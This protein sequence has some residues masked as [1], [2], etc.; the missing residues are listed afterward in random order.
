MARCDTLKHT[1]FWSHL[2]RERSARIFRSKQGKQGVPEKAKQ[3]KQGAFKTYPLA[4]A[5]QAKQGLTGRAKQ[6]PPPFKQAPP[7]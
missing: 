3:A 6:G 1:M 4:R 7:V 5:K 2:R